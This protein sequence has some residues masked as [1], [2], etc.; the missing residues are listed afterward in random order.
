MIR[1]RLP[2][3]LLE[4]ER[5][6]GRRIPWR[7][8][9]RATGISRQVLANLASRERAVVTNTA[10]LEAICRYFACAVNDLVELTP[11]VQPG[12]ECHIDSLYPTRR[13]RGEA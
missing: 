10:Y 4:K 9:S 12:E 5:Q 6:E 2:E 7:D 3:L 13:R 1:F 8:V 11:P